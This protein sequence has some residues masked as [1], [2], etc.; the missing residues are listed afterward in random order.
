MRIACKIIA[1][2][3]WMAITT[4][5]ITMIASPRWITSLSTRRLHHLGLLTLSL[6][7]LHHRRL[8]PYRR[9]TSQPLRHRYRQSF[10][11]RF[12]PY[13]RDTSASWRFWK[14]TSCNPPH[15]RKD[16]HRSRH[17]QYRWGLS[18]T[19]QNLAWLS[20]Y[21]RNSVLLTSCSCLRWSL[22]PS[23]VRS[24]LTHQ[25]LVAFWGLGS[26]TKK[27]GRTLPRKKSQDWYR[28]QWPFWF[29]V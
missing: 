28:L 21:R 14:V 10:H 19:W 11:S 4:T 2:S 26:F 12:C 6:K 3:S 9:L 7:H 27:K 25:V 22:A 1:F 16:Y 20:C 8:L 18:A 24:C 13:C 15:W 29:Q 17:T 5:R 23:Q